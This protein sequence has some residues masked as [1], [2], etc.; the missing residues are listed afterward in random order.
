MSSSSSD[1]NQPTRTRPPQVLQLP[2]S[3]TDHAFFRNT[4]NIN[5]EFERYFLEFD[6]E[7]YKRVKGA[8]SCSPRMERPEM[9]SGRKA[10]AEAN[11]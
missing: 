6:K 7:T 2:K 11:R 9:V 3:V 1:A 5:D 8:R 4:E 10:E